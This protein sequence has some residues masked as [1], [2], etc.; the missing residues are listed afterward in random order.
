MFHGTYYD[1]D[2]MQAPLE[3][4]EKYDLVMCQEVAEHIDQEFESHIL[5]TFT[6]AAAPESTLIFGAARVGQ[7]GEHHVNCQDKPYW[8]ERLQDRGWVLDD[9]MSYYYW[10]LCEKSTIVRW[11]YVENTMCFTRSAPTGGDA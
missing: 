1:H 5:D 9:I 3:P 7:G 2:M 6:L 8:I 11:W 10:K 4:N